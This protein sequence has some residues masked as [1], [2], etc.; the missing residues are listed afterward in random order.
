MFCDEYRDGD[1]E[2]DLFSVNWGLCC[3]E[4]NDDKVYDDSFDYDYFN[5]DDDDNDD[6]HM[7][8]DMALV[9]LTNVITAH[10]CNIN[11]KC[12]N[13]NHKCNNNHKCNKI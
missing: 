8:M 2:P 13:I 1:D 5:D 10:K 7:Y 6:D 11:H 4:G 9:S 3:E 12:N